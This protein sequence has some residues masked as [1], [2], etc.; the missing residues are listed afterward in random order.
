MNSK[1]YEG[2]LIYTDTDG[3]LFSTQEFDISI[4]ISADIIKIYLT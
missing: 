2:C 1:P 4:G 3:T